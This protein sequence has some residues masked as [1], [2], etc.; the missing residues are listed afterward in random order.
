MKVIIFEVKQETWGRPL[1]LFWK[2]EYETLMKHILASIKL[3]A[4]M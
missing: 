1:E 4:I 3:K 2:S